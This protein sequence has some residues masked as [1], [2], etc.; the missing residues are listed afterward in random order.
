M[1]PIRILPYRLATAGMHNYLDYNVTET[2]VRLQVLLMN[3]AKTIFRSSLAL[4]NGKKYLRTNKI[5][6]IMNVKTYFKFPIKRCN[7]Y[8][9]I[10]RQ[11]MKYDH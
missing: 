11:M 8:E 6:T 1:S 10:V 4:R 5:I 2:S 9:N 7:C 3:V